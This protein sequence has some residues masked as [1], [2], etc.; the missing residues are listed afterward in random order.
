MAVLQIRLFP[1]PILRKRCT[2]V[3]PSDPKLRFLSKDLEH[4]LYAQ[5]GGIGIAAPQVGIDKR[6][7]LIDISSK[8]PTKHLEVMINPVILVQ[9]GEVLSREGCMSLPDY[10]ANVKR[11][12]RLQ[13]EWTDIRGWKKEKTAHGIEAICIQ[14]EIDHLNG[15]LFIDRVVSLKTDVFPR[16]R[17]AR[18]PRD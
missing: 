5:T 11:F 16:Q 12:E 13:L 7:I 8:D 1:D 17:R 9:E 3:N 2:A 6:L 10:T 18:K 15:M 14:H 4:T